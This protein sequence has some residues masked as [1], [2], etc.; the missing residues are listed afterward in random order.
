[1]IIVS[2]YTSFAPKILNYHYPA[3]IGDEPEFEGNQSTNNFTESV[4]L[5]NC[6]VTEEQEYNLDVTTNVL[7]HIF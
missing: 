4:V 7:V 5:L 1:M 6:K 2:L 3:D